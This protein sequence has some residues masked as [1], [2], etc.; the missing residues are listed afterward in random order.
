MDYKT[1]KQRRRIVDLMLEVVGKEGISPPARNR[2]AE[3]FVGFVKTLCPPGLRNSL[4]LS[5]PPTK[6]ELD[7]F[8]NHVRKCVEDPDYRKKADEGARSELEE[9]S[10]KNYMEG[11]RPDWW[12]RVREDEIRWDRRD[13]LRYDIRQND[14]WSEFTRLCG[15]S[16]P[17]EEDLETMTDF[18]NWISSLDDSFLQFMTSSWVNPFVRGNHNYRTLNHCG[19]AAWAAFRFRALG[20][21]IIEPSPDLVRKLRCTR[22]KM[23]VEHVKIPLPC[24]AIR[25]EEPVWYADDSK[26]GDPRPLNMI[27]VNC[28]RDPISKWREAE[29]ENPD[30]EPVQSGIEMIEDLGR[31]PWQIHING[32]WLSGD[33]RDDQIQSSPGLIMA[34]P[35]RSVEEAVQTQ[36]DGGE[37]LETEWDRMTGRTSNEG[38]MLEQCDSM[39]LFVMNLIVHMSQLESEGET[40]EPDQEKIEECESSLSSLKSKSK[41][42]KVKDE[43]AQEEER[44]VVLGDKSLSPSERDRYDKLLNGTLEERRIHCKF[45]VRGHPHNYWV[46]SKDDPGGQRLVTKWVE[47]YWKGKEHELPESD[48]VYEAGG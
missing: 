4:T 22:L 8:E 43:L 11:D 37:L 47:P 26:T 29:R 38:R 1:K 13:H 45:M 6:A 33:G 27:Y 32:I 23:P 12:K 9:R 24:F 39:S 36:D 40:H 48:R 20:K 35:G 16:M 21:N 25:L 15:D 2:L 3:H 28:V 42:R 46:G 7:H 31:A 41:R 34:P 18:S 10:K 14:M 19:H 17:G 5:D 30:C 44:R